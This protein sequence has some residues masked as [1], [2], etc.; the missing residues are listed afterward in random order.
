MCK[1][2]P[3]VLSLVFLFSSAAQAIDFSRITNKESIIGDMS[4]N[5]YT[6]SE[7]QRLR[8]FDPGGLSRLRILAEVIHEAGICDVNVVRENY[9]GIDVVNSDD[10]LQQML[11]IANNESTLGR[12][13]GGI[14]GRGAWGINPMHRTGICREFPLA[15][16]RSKDNR[17]YTSRAARLQN[18][19]CAIK[20]YKDSALVPWGRTTAWGS[21][22]HCSRSDR[23]RMNFVRLLGERLATCSQR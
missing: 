5:A 7:M 20:L 1:V 17:H 19:K 13:N 3:L 15:T 8:T 14:G 10:L 2:Y 18:A 12:D 22:R 6:V 9:L 16:R 4:T 23:E 11:C 21:N